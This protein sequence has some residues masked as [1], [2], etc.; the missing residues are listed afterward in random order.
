MIEFGTGNLR[1]PKW[2]RKV[3]MVAGGVTA[4]RTDYADLRLEELVFE[5]F[6]QLVDDNDLKIGP[7]D[8]RKRIN[9]AVY[10]NFSNAPQD[11]TWGEARVHDYLGLDPVCNVGIKTGGAT[12][13]SA[14]LVG[15]QAVASGY[16]DCVLVAAWEY[17]S[18]AGVADP[19]WSGALLDFDAGPGGN[20]LNHYAS[21]ANRFALSR[22]LTEETRAKVAVKNRSYA[23]NNP[24]ALEGRKC[25]V[26]EVLAS[27]VV[28]YPLRR[29]ECATPSAGAATVLLCSERVARMLSDRPC[30]LFIAGGSH[31]LRA[32]DRR[33]VAQIPLLPHE[34]PGMYDRILEDSDRWPGFESFLG[35]RM[36]AYLAYR[37]A[38]VKDP[39]E[40]LDLVELH[41]ATTIT[42]IQ[43]YG[44]IGL[45]PYGQE[46]GYIE[47]LDSYFGGKCP[48]NLSGG[49][50]GSSHALGASGVYQAAEC[51]WQIQDKYDQFHGDPKIWRKWGKRKP[52]NQ[53]SLQVPGARQ[54]MWVSHCGIGAH[55]TVGVLKK[56]F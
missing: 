23:V 8:L 7:I 41:D 28:A 22:E 10:G 43:T 46:A 52:K 26:R 12:G 50:L 17:N 48:A 39:L 32:G 4:L 29:L 16:A 31:T 21:L 25:T 6:K 3:Y 49:L 14:V 13:G 56:F 24:Y 27:P 53:T 19:P 18:W 38:G 47:S 1:I 36:A 42:D 37:M 40:E 9:F 34:E 51:L 15:A 54:A 45:R 44:D 20:Y 2:S 11:Q 35:A 5:A 55:V 33:H 30:Q